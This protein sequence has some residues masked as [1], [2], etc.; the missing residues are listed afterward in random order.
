M[1]VQNTRNGEKMNNYVPQ[2]MTISTDIQRVE[3]TKHAKERLRIRGQLKL[4]ELQRNNLN[5][6]IEL[7]FKRSKI[8]RKVDLVPFYIHKNAANSKGKVYMSDSKM[9][10]YIWKYIPQRKAALIITIVV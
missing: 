4:N 5:E 6:F 8:D 7:D 3:I 9:F 10:R 2:I 1:V